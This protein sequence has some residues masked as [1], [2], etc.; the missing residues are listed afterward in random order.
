M[1]WAVAMPASGYDGLTRSNM[2]D[3]FGRERL[4]QEEDSWAEEAPTRS[5]GHGTV[6]DRHRLA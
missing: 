6:E 3:Y 2:I 4:E 1:A 5:R